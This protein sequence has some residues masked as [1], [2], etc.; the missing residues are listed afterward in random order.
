MI[1]K[2]AFSSYSESN[3]IP[4]MLENL[5]KASSKMTN[6][7]I[8][9]CSYCPISSPRFFPFFSLCNC[10]RLFDYA[11]C[12]GFALFLRAKVLIIFQGIHIK[13][14]TLVS[15]Y[16]CIFN[17]SLRINSSTSA[18]ILSLLYK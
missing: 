10:L 3:R 14:L 6:F 13:V 15:F 7:L 17:N 8:P 5:S 18:K 4:L 9:I 16:Q 11:T 12:N 1:L 2:L